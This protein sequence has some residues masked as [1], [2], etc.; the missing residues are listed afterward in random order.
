MEKLEQLLKRED[1]PEDVKQIIKERINALDAQDSELNKLNELYKI[2]YKVNT[3]LLKEHTIGTLELFI[4]DICSSLVTE[5][6]FKLAWIGKTNSS[7]KIVTPIV[8]KGEA[9]EYAHGLHISLDDSA[10]GHGPTAL[11]IKSGTIYICN[12][13]H[14]DPNTL[15]WRDRALNFGLKSSAVFP[16]PIS[17]SVTWAISVYSKDVNF[18]QEEEI[19]LLDEVAKNISLGIKNIYLKTEQKIAEAKLIASNEKFKKV[20]ENISDAIYIL[21]SNG[22]VQYISS[23]V[24]QITKYTPK[25]IIN[26]SLFSYVH[27]DDLPNILT[28]FKKRLSGIYESMDWRIKTKDGNTKYVNTIS[29][30]ILDETGAKLLIGVLRDIDERK[31]MEDTLIATK[32]KAE[33]SDRLKSAFLANMSHEIRTPMNAIM[34]FSYLLKDIE[35]ITSEQEMYANR[36]YASGERL[37]TL[38]NDI[39][40]LSKIDAKQMRLDYKEKIVGES[41]SHV[42]NLLYTKIVE[43]KIN[44][45]IKFEEENYLINT[46]HQKLEQILI[47]LV[48]NSIKFTQ[49]GIIEIGCHKTDSKTL[50]FYV[51]DTGIG[52]SKENQE[53]IFNAFRQAEEDTGKKYGGT[54]LGLTIS[55]E[56]V[57]LMGGTIG[58]ESNEGVGSKF[59]FTL[60]FEGKIESVKEEVKQIAP[61]LNQD[62]KGAKLLLVEDEDCN[63]NLFKEYFRKLN[64]NFVVAYNGQEALNIVE[65]DPEINII[66]MDIKMPTM[67]GITATKKLRERGIKTPIIAQSAY[68]MVG[69]KEKFLSAGCDDYLSKPLDRD[70]LINV[71]D[72]YIKQ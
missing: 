53:N 12:D 24:T 15:P 55:K 59:Y 40:D 61:K 54:G 2:L 32:E 16:I 69:D 4:E 10:I 35:D 60:P 11:A 1:I 8:I 70:Q 20:V 17:D 36:I 52:I 18:F 39:L 19:K 3:A 26:T 71:L 68:A 62:Y 21:D 33:E 31:K 30:T 25:E 67:D 23:A 29:N 45:E 9:S 58:V 46:D 34:G 13:F 72:K 43:K 27:K 28:K 47:N 5:S 41:L 48:G 37:L 65:K 38:I 14:N 56:L 7:T 57:E 66:F 22:V 49:N 44:L 50:L 6:R 51:Q 42:I 64:V 63:I